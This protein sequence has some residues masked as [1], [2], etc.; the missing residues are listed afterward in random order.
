M[1]DLEVATVEE[2]RPVVAMSPTRVLPVKARDIPSMFSLAQRAFARDRHTLMKVEEKGV[3]DLSSE[4][5][6]A[7]DMERFLELGDGRYRLIKAVA[8]D[9]D[10]EEDGDGTLLGY[11]IW[12]LSCIGQGG[13][14]VSESCS[15][16]TPRADPSGRWS[17]V[18]CVPVSSVSGD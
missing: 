6:P 15:F 8:A 13:N 2:A 14:G 10:E 5:L 1:L 11:T 12:G 7:R 18:P 9:E 16:V 17:I 4:L 3:P